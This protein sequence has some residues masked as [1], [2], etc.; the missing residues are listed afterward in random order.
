MSSSINM[1]NCAIVGYGRNFN[2]GR[3]HG[4]W[5]NACDEM[6]LAAVCDLDPASLDAAEAD[7]P[8]IRTFADLGEML[9]A[10]DPSIDVVSIVTPH[11]THAPL[12]IRCLAA[13]KHVVV[14]KPMA[15]RVEDCDSMIAAAT[16]N[17]RVL[18]VFHN[19]R[20]DG[21]YRAIRQVIDEGRIG[22]VFHIE[23]C[24][25]SYAHP[26]NWWY[27]QTRPSGG[28]FFFWGPH[29]VDWVLQ[30]KPNNKPVA[31]VG[32]EKKPA[33]KDVENNDEVR[34]M[35]QFDDDS[36]AM[37]TF[38]TVSA[39][40]RPMWRILG[41]KGAIEDRAETP[42]PGAVIKGY[43]EDLDAP[44]CGTMRVVEAS[45]DGKHTESEIP[46]LESTWSG[47]YRELA[48]HI[49]HD[50]PIPV[51]AMQGRAAIAIIEAAMKSSVSGQVVRLD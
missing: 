31:V 26:G 42:I 14:D 15:T 45:S 28:V 46:Y 34:C 6:Q 30:L 47:Y 25:E 17:N 10:K 20:R 1:L 16:S 9:E 50:E 43:C 24:E 4:R 5:I 40:R 39:V 21:N 37:I 2:F 51:S 23:C 32:Y 48:A 33:W 19:R 7:F 38:S 41:S 13:G 44:P 3:M 12:T 22:D 49:L 35:V 8:G 29:A 18:A 27:T 36:T 11:H